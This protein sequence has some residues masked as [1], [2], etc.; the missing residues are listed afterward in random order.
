MRS[1]S[2][3]HN[4]QSP[5]VRME[6]ELK[7]PVCLRFYCNPLVLPCSHSLCAGCARSLQENTQPQ[8]SQN[9]EETPVINEQSDIIKDFP[10]ID[11]VSVVS[12]TDSGVVCNSRPNS[13]VGT[14]SIGNLFQAIHG[15]SYSIKCPVC[16]KNVY[17]DEKGYNSLPKNKVL[18]T[19]VEKYA[20]DH[21]QVQIAVKCELCEKESKNASVMCEQCEVFYCD[22]CRDSCHPSRGPLAQHNLVDPKQGKAILRA[23]NKGKEI[24]CLEHVEEHLSM[25]CL[26][27]KLSV[28]YICHQD[29]QHISH[30][31]QAL[32]AMSKSQKVGPKTISYIP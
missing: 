2:T 18:E 12:E 16:K 28:C 27:C 1:S 11:K 24:K 25:Y 3:L 20:V 31:V 19:I 21:E 30:D 6:E 22:S 15:S 29:G 23:K 26:V 10:D 7:C 17:L 14:P 8:I 32:G 4:L 9:I 5:Q 13:Y